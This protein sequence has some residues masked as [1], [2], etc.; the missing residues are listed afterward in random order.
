[1]D[2]IKRCQVTVVAVNDNVLC[3]CHR[4]PVLSQYPE[5]TT[6]DCVSLLVHLHQRSF[7][8]THTNADVKKQ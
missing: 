1:M 2:E 6:S 5:S 4:H 8:R 7:M 3:F